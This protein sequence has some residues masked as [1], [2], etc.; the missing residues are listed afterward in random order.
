MKTIKNMLLVMFLVSFV[1]LF[2]TFIM[3]NSI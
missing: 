1:A 2:M 3:Y